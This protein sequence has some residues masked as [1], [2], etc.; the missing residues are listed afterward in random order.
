MANDL[1][2]GF[3]DFIH[4]PSTWSNTQPQLIFPGP[5]LSI[6]RNQRIPTG[7]QGARSWRPVD[8]LAL[9]L[10]GDGLETIGITAT[11]Q[12]LFDHNGDGIKT[13]TG[14]VKGDD[15][16]L[17]LDKNANGTIDNGNEL[18]GVDTVLSNGQKATSGFAALAD[19][20]SN[21]DGQFSS[22]DA[23]YAN[24]QIWR[25]LD[26]DCIS[27]AG[28]LQTLAQAGIASLNL[29]STAGTTNFGN[30]NTQS[31]TATYTRTDGSTGTAA[32]LNLAANAFYREFGDKIALTAAAAALPGLQGAGLVRD[33]QE[34]ASLNAALVQD[35]ASLTGLSRLEMLGQL[36]HLLQDWAGTATFKT[37]QQ[38]AAEMGFT[39]MFK[40]PGVTDVELQAV[41]IIGQPGF[42]KT[43]T[44]MTLGVS[45]DRYNTVKAQVAEMG[46]MM[47]VLEAF[48]GQTFLNF[49][50]D[51]SIKTG[52]DALVSSQNK[53]FSAL[54]LASAG[55]QT[56]TTPVV[57]SYTFVLPTLTTQQVDLLKQS[58]TALKESVYEGMVGQTRLKDYLDTISLNIDANGISI[59]FAALDAKLNS[60]YQTDSVRAFTDCL[61]LQKYVSGLSGMGWQGAAK[62]VAWSTDAATHG[63]LDSLKAGLALAFAT[64]SNGV[65]D[66]KIGTSGAEMLSAGASDDIVIGQAG[67]DTLYGGAGNDILDGGT[68]N[69]YLS[70]DAGSDVYL[71]G[72]GSGQDTVYNYDATAGKTDA[73]Q[74]AAGIAN[75]DV[76]VSRSGDNLV[77]SINGT[78]DNLTVS[79][80]FN[81]DAAGYYKVEEIR[82]ADGTVWNVDAIK[83]KVLM[84]TSG[85]DNLYG[86]ATS[87][88]ISGGEG[89]DTISGY[90]G[91]DTLNGESGAD[92]LYG[93]DGTDTLNG[94]DGADCLNGDNGNDTLNGGTGTDYLYGGAGNDTLDGGA[95]NDY[96]SGDAGNDVYLFGRGSGQDTITNYDSTAGKTDA[97]QF[98]AGIASS[99]VMLTRS[100]DSLVLS[101]AGTSDKLTVSSYFNSDAAGY[102]KV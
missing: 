43:L 91:D 70:G 98:A 85:N 82:F 40:V 90:A 65:P 99:D 55:T 88:T 86:Y 24:V 2:K 81:S 54:A 67:K 46:K 33:L 61:D 26:Q 102:Y 8:P 5:D 68:G 58:Y 92:Y 101:S 36:D 38:R 10:D 34:A 57:S 3:H 21:H 56:N 80:Y 77:L 12:T 52:L 64:S 29:T 75:S 53:D 25:D 42:D 23:Q 47:G 95:G 37:S 96:L 27:D 69:D 39:L 11:A 79:S 19:L 97:I 89:N 76:Q 9:D 50:D 35:V 6:P 22:A 100:G 16:L 1:G 84:P 49:G 15:A 17:V 48:N 44:L 4:D 20:D 59:N 18:F 83:A 14:W 32:N 31:A 71:F 93:G 51:G 30:G 74:F 87:D 7:F 94:G 60:L 63:T 13:G 41:Q 62:L 28:E 66:I 78:A 73:I 72:R 45:E